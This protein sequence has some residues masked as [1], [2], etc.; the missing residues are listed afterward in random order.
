M[1]CL[2]ESFKLPNSLFGKKALAIKLRSLRRRKAKRGS[3]C[4][5]N[6]IKTFKKGII[7]SCRKRLES[8]KERGSKEY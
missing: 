5:E 6:S 1:I 8:E 7:E 2:V 4:R 3:L